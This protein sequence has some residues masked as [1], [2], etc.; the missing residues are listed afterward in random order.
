MF[1]IAS[2]RSEA[3]ELKDT[4]KQKYNYAIGINPI[5]LAFGMINATYEQKLSRTNSFTVSG[6]FFTISDWYAIGLSGSYRFYYKLHDGQKPALEGFSF[7]PLLSI[8]YWNFTGNKDARNDYGGMSIAIGGEVA[9]KWAFT[10]NF[11]IEP[12]INVS[13]NVLKITGDPTYSLFHGGVAIGYA[14]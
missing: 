5:G 4:K 9:Y 7:G 8:A 12:T 3:Q 14:W 13:I 1:A 6:D 11:Y 10:D 2:V